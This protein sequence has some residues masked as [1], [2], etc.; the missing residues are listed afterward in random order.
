MGRDQ[1]GDGPRRPLRRSP[2]PRRACT[3]DVHPLPKGDPRT[4]RA[5]VA[6]RK[7]PT[8]HPLWYFATTMRRAVAAA[9]F[10]LSSPVAA[11]R[12]RPRAAPDASLDTGAGIDA[13]AGDAIGARDRVGH[14]RRRR[15]GRSD[16]GMHGGSASGPTWTTSVCAA[17]TCVPACATGLRRLRRQSHRRVRDEPPGEPCALQELPRGLLGRRRERH[18]PERRLAAL[19]PRKRAPATATWTAATGARQTSATCS[20]ANCRFCGNACTYAHASGICS[21]GTPPARAVRERRLRRLR[22]PPAAERV[23]DAADDRRQPRQLRPCVRHRRR[24]G[25]GAA[26]RAASRRARPGRHLG[27]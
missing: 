23:R 25:L 24:D 17:D 16:G 1:R 19:V 27:L 14:G 7:W 26:G 4:A 2:A 10:S 9:A 20:S 8:L 22:R 15:A 12:L 5:D 11:W 6:R 18:L 21:G 3:A 13:A